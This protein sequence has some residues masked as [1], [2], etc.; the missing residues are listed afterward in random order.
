MNRPA[1]GQRHPRRFS[2]GELFEL[3]LVL[4]F[5]AAAPARTKAVVSQQPAC[6]AVLPKC[7]GGEGLQPDGV[8]VLDHERGE[9]GADAHALERVG[10][11]DRE[12]GDI[13]SSCVA[14]VSGDC[15]DR[16]VTLIDR[17]DG[18]VVAAINVG[19]E[20]QLAQCCSR[21]GARKRW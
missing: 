20:R 6:R 4:D 3:E 19:E 5:G 13:R 7:R 9:G 15:H 17:G 2:G 12:L 14:H 1:V 18:L 10:D 21:L 8:R 16:V 11:L